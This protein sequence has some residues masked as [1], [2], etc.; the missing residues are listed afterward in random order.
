MVAA[1][2]ESPVADGSDAAAPPMG[3]ELPP[4]DALLG[5]VEAE[6]PVL[7]ALELADPPGVEPPLPGWLV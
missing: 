3:L 7:V 6:L 5:C 2:V 4:A 1:P